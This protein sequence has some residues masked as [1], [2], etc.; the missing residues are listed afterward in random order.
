MTLPQALATAVDRQSIKF[1]CPRCYHRMKAANKYAGRKF[2][3]TACGLKFVI[4]APTYGM[5]LRSNVVVRGSAEERRECKWAM[6]SEKWLLRKARLKTVAALSQLAYCGLARLSRYG[7][8]H[9]FGIR[10]SVIVILGAVVGAIAFVLTESATHSVLASAVGVFTIAMLLYLP[11]DRG[12]QEPNRQ[13]LVTLGVLA[14][15]RRER[16]NLIASLSQRIGDLS[17]AET[18]QSRG[19][20]TIFVVATV[21]VLLI[22]GFVWRSHRLRE[23]EQAKRPHEVQVATPDAVDSSSASTAR[24]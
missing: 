10:W 5:S 21:V 20:W 8:D 19:R 18:P 24:E 13:A 23:D 2:K 15:E 14:A 22:A 9:T 16:N 17:G 12:L 4:V 1:A 3:C 11:S 7:A 6:R